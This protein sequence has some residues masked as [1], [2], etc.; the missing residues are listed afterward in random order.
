[1]KV[2]VWLALGFASF[3]S[4]W[5]LVAGAAEINH[6]AISKRVIRDT[7]RVFG[8][9]AASRIAA[10]SEL[11]TNNKDKPI[12]EKLA[13]T[14]S[15][16]NRVPVKSEEEIWGHMHWSTPFEMLLHNAGSQADHT[17]AKYITLEAMGISIDHMTITHVHSMKSSN[18]SYMVLTY[19]EKRGVVPLV[20]DTMNDEIKPADQ[21]TDLF[22]EDS[23]NDSGL[24]LS[25]KQKDE[26]N[27]AQE[28]AAVHVEL[29][30]DMNARLD[31]EH[32]STE[33]PGQM[34]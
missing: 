2:P 11:V 29:W 3:F 33:D 31:K 19:H 1:M 6:A 8:P 20:L 32:L 30:N 17:I 15:F 4:A 13:L 12:T 14:N 28:E 7:E 34:W 24:W 9:G 16:F 10:W 22:P 25:N 26:R 21:R 18:L 27:D 5:M 23:L